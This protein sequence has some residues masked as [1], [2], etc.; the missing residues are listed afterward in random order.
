MVDG[1]R[2]IDQ[3]DLQF[4]CAPVRCINGMSFTRFRGSI[5]FPLLMAAGRNSSKK[6][7]F[8]FQVP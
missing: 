2:S 6:L 1:H 7:G 5:N 3:G 8:V 4:C